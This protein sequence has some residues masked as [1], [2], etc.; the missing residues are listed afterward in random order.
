MARRILIITECNWLA[1]IYINFFGL[2][3]WRSRLLKTRQKR[4]GNLKKTD[5]LIL[6]LKSRKQLIKD[7]NRLRTIVPGLKVVCALAHKRSPIR[8][9]LKNEGIREFVSIDSGLLEEAFRQKWVNVNQR[10][11]KRKRRFKT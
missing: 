9:F 7:I 2:I 8:E 1:K 11:K 6:P 3:G 10:V 4:F 5:A